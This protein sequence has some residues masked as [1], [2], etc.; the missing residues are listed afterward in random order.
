L[1]KP[2]AGL[3]RCLTTD[4][5]R[6]LRI[7][8]AATLGVVAVV[9]GTPLREPLSEVFSPRYVARVLSVL[10]IP[11]LAGI[12]LAWIARRARDAPTRAAAALVL[13]LYVAL[14]LRTT[15]LRGFVPPSNPPTIPARPELT[16][17]GNLFDQRVVLARAK[18][19]YFLPF[20]TGAFV[21][22]NHMGHSNPYAWNSER[23]HGARAI[24]NGR[25]TPEEIRRYAE[26]FEV[27][28]ALLPEN[29]N[30][31]IDPLVASGAF[32][33]RMTVPGYVVLERITRP[34]P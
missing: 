9:L 19:A 2:R 27:D 3:A 26:E 33:R 5:S 17:L 22:W 30:Q 20:F 29:R 14:P 1:V 12:G 21:V 6:A 34:A 24:I 16:M 25:A 32:R 18:D 8:L 10:P 4:T 28:F 23:V 15:E 11:A 31:T 13:A 7:Y